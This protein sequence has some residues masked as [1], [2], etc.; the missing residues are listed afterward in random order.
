M[1][2]ALQTILSFITLTEIIPYCQCVCYECRLG[3]EFEKIK[4]N[5]EMKARNHEKKKPNL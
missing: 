1:S 5:E 2:L 3:V 4:L